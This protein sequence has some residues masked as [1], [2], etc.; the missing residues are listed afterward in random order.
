MVTPFPRDERGCYLEV[1]PQHVS[2][3]AGIQEL[4][5]HAGV[6]HH[7]ICAVG[8]ERNDLSMIRGAA[9][10]VAMGNAHPEVQAAAD[11]VTGRHDEDGLVAV[12][13]RILG[14]AGDGTSAPVL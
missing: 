7:A 1:V 2:K 10:G 8:D 14:P 11:W 5:S 4:A 13:E 6:P 12:V 9:L 3:W